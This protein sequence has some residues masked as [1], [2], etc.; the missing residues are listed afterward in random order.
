MKKAFDFKVIVCVALFFCRSVT[1]QQLGE[2]TLMGNEQALAEK[3][4][5][6]I[7]QVSLKRNPSGPI[8]R[9]NQVK[10]QGCFLGT[11]DV[12][13]D[14]P[15]D[16]KHGLFSK[17]ETY[18][19]Y[20]R[21][22]NAS[23]MDDSEKDLR[24]LSLMVEKV[25]GDMIWGRQGQQHFLLN[26]HPVLFAQSPEEFYDFIQAQL[27]DS[28]LSFFLNPFDS[29][30]NALAI[31]LSARDKPNS[32][33]D[34]RYWS[35]TAYQL[36]PQHQAVKYSVKSCSTYTSPEPEEYAA[37]YLRTAMRAHLERTEACFDFMVQPQTDAEE[38][39]IEDPTVEWDE[40]ISP[41]TTV[42]R[43]IIQNQDFLSPQAMS[44]CEAASF[45]PWQSLIEHKPLGRVNR[46][47]RLVYEALAELRM[48][49][50]K[51]LAEK[52]TIS[53]H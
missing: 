45:N 16:L 12:L 21:F 11:F 52:V 42:A 19:L 38:M 20:A 53:V 41:F 33:F 5:Q 37:D 1:A 36:G 7:T 30:L 32:L 2:E 44:Q 22:A 31:L 23:T 24:G 29:H 10:S 48:Q 6:L 8:S 47:R 9:L 51:T 49:R 18:P 35:T 50:R 4:T 15:D 25:K 43:I 14:I 40:D 26:S 39:P 28:I 34:I 27:N 13:G 46:V 17:N 3:L